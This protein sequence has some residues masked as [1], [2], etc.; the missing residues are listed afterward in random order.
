MS[1]ITAQDGNVIAADFGRRDCLG[2]NVT[3]KSDILYF[4]GHVCLVRVIA[5]LD[6]QPFM[7]KH[8]MEEAPTD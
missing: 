5:S 6:G 8:F 3:F 1:R 7:T 4:D 2:L